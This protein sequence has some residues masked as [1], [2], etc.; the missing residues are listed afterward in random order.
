[1]KQK[2]VSE[3]SQKYSIISMSSGL[4]EV[5]SNSELNKISEA[6]SNVIHEHRSTLSKSPS[7]YTPR[8]HKVKIKKP[9]KSKVV[10]KK[11]AK[12]K[13]V[14]SKPEAP[15]SWADSDDMRYAMWWDFNT[16]LSKGEYPKYKGIKVTPYPL[17]EQDIALM[18]QRTSDSQRERAKIQAIKACGI[19]PRNELK[20]PLLGSAPH[21]ANRDLFAF[22]LSCNDEYRKELSYRYA[23][24]CKMTRDLENLGW[25]EPLNFVDVLDIQHEASYAKATDVEVSS[26]IDKL[27]VLVRKDNQAIEVDQPTVEDVFIINNIAKATSEVFDIDVN[28]CMPFATNDENDENV[29]DTD[30]PWAIEKQ[31]YTE[32]ERTILHMCGKEPWPDGAKGMLKNYYRSEGARYVQWLARRDS[33]WLRNRV[34]Y[35]RWVALPEYEVDIGTEVHPMYHVGE[36]T[37]NNLIKHYQP[38]RISLFNFGIID[39]KNFKNSVGHKAVNHKYGIDKGVSQAPDISEKVSS[40]VDK[41][42]TKDFVDKITDRYVRRREGK[43]YSDWIRG[44]E[45]KYTSNVTTASP[46]TDSPTPMT[47]SIFNKW[48]QEHAEKQEAEIVSLDSV[49]KDRKDKLANFQ[50]SIGSRLKDLTPEQKEGAKIVVDM[51]N[52]MLG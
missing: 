50:L 13:K 21:P 39:N 12:E 18:E 25:K 23:E 31:S 47:D 10:N 4:I 15:S 46:S 51:L 42:L 6:V 11:P 30:V 48:D 19:T 22:G 36:D 34:E 43:T 38:R 7:K 41:Q 1:M 32:E 49:R 9:K 52:E 33:A 44:I 8:S 35:A 45:S 14:M 29:S 2:P 5:Q 17:S 3:E 26:I 37:Y 20:N 40:A 28:K 24:L 16:N 27:E